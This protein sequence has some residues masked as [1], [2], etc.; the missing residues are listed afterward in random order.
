MKKLIKS[1]IILGLI[2]FGM[3]TVL[4]SSMTTDEYAIHSEILETQIAD[5]ADEI[6][7]L[8]QELARLESQFNQMQ[9]LYNKQMSV[10]DMYNWFNLCQIYDARANVRIN[11]KSYNIFLGIQTSSNN[12]GGSGAIIK[13]E[14]NTIYVLTSYYV[15]E[16][17]SN[18]KNI[19]Y[20]VEDAFRNSY[21]ASLKYQSKEYGLSIL[22]F[23]KGIDKL[24]AVPLANEDPKVNKPICNIF[25]L[26]DSAL[27]HMNFTTV[28]YITVDSQYTEFVMFANEI[29]TKSNIYG[30]M[31]V[32]INGDLIAIT[33]LT[34]D[35]S[36]IGVPVSKVKE[37][38]SSKGFSI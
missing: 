16:L 26:S 33:L 38:L 35:D 12:V 23:T 1:L 2:F 11:A 10:D 24:Y 5:I 31:S 37:F 6:A 34:N 22:M 7:D 25:S 3:T 13:K 28:S 17:K 30:S 8:K 27:N 15:T 29:D 14:G 20:T 18:Y 4:G 36:C 19:E 32:D 9:A 21:K